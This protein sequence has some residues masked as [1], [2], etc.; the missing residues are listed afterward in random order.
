ML[1]QRLITA[2]ILLGLLLVLGGGFA[3]WNYINSP[4][5]ALK[6]A[7]DAIEAKDFDTFSEYVDIK[8]LSESI[9]KDYAESQTT[10]MPEFIKLLLERNKTI[11]SRNLETALKSFF[12][13][14]RF[15][16]EA[17]ENATGLLQ[18]DILQ[19]MPNLEE[20]IKKG[21]E[22]SKDKL[23]GIAYKEMQGNLLIAGI[24]INESN[25]GTDKKIIELQFEKHNGHWRLVGVQNLK[26][27][28]TQK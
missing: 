5:Y 2:G 28:M 17:K 10:A 24:E 25:E 8:K 19:T 15:V 21:I 7:R 26:V 9:I 20:A 11:L 13:T 18:I 6:Q 12:E 16:S 23:R 3:Y 27:F 14:G 4:E 1:K 22:K